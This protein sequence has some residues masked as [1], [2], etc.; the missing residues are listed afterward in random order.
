MP[1]TITKPTSQVGITTNAA[2]YSMTGVFLPAAQDK[3]LVFAHASATVTG[4]ISGVGGLT[5]RTLGSM[6]PLG[7]GFSTRLFVADV[8]D[9]PSSVGINIDYTGD[10][11][12]GCT[13]AAIKLSGHDGIYIRQYAQVNS[14]GPNPTLTFPLAVLSAN[15]YAVAMAFLSTVAPPQPVAAPAGWTT[16]A[17]SYATPA[18]GLTLGYRT[19][20]E[21][22]QTFVMSTGVV[23]RTAIWGVEI[24]AAGAIP[25]VD[26]M[27]VS[28]IFGY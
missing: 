1:I 19:Q 13:A 3:L 17:A 8:V 4:S 23:S 14:W 22:G 12:T 2:V 26:P 7:L 5:W 10:A 20:G 21:D 18:C 16:I 24:W 27:G 6:N 25:S 15:A 28:G 9:V 11:A